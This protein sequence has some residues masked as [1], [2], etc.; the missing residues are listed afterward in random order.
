MSWILNVLRPFARLTVGK[1]PARTYGT[2]E[3]DPATLTL[4]NDPANNRQI[5]AAV[6][7]GYLD[8]SPTRNLVAGA[9][10]TGGGDLSADRTFNIIAADG[11]IDVQ[12]NTIAVGVISDAQHGARGGGELHALAVS[13]G[14][15]GFMSGADKAA[16]DTNT[17][18]I[19][20]ATPNPTPTT[21]AERN[22]AGEC[23]F[24]RVVPTFTDVAASGFIGLPAGPLSIMAWDSTANPGSDLSALSVET[25]D[26]LILGG[27]TVPTT[28]IKGEAVVVETAT[29]TLTLSVATT[30]TGNAA[31]AI[32]WQIG[33][34]SRIKVDTTG[35][36][37]FNVA[38]AAKQTV[39]G[40]CRGNAALS[41]L[42]GDLSRYGLVTDSTTGGG[43]LDIGV[44]NNTTTSI[45]LDA[46][47]EFVTFANAGAV[48]VNLPVGVSGRR[49]VLKNKGAGTATLTPNG[50]QKL[51]T[52][53]Q[54]STLAMVTGD[55]KT[56][57]FDGTD[58]SVV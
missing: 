13:G 30:L 1:I 11:S 54:V 18:A 29:T 40:S 41:G 24:A 10:L 57:V 22:G 42:I 34:T 15:E 38:P 37:F 3:I 48:T 17:T 52:T 27:D 6:G 44:T 21:I 39:T 14:D 51:F 5:L 26:V 47:H 55:A 31:T 35:L 33:G 20:N 2:L 32:D 16:H 36:G 58:W 25:G 56:I 53:S 23:A 46:S 50:S 4:T 19:T 45:T 28:T 12:A 8:V 43:S 49:Y 7:T 9:G